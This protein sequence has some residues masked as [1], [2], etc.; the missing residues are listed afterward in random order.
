MG[1]TVVVHSPAQDSGQSVDIIWLRWLVTL[2]VDTAL[3]DASLYGLLPTPDSRVDKNV[4]S[5]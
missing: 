2:H 3:F 1:P 4:Q 5:L